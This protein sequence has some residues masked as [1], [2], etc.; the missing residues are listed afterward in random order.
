MS[1]KIQS[2]PPTPEYTR[3]Y[4]EIEWRDKGTY[5]CRCGRTFKPG[6][7]RDID[8]DGDATCTPDCNFN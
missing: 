3:N 8:K 4:E 7:P 6:D 1:E 2:R 5:C